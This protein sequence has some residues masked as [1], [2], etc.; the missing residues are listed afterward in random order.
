MPAP[1]GSDRE[2]TERGDAAIGC[3]EKYPELHKQP[4][5]ERHGVSGPHP[6]CRAML[7]FTLAI[8]FLTDALG[9]RL[10]L[11]AELMCLRHQVAVLRRQRGGRVELTNGDRWFMVLFFRL[12]PEIAKRSSLVTPGTLLRWHRGGFRAY[13]R[14]KSRAK[15]GRPR[16]DPATIALIKRMARENFLWGAPRIHGELLK[17]GFTIAESTVAKYMPRRR[18]DGPTWRT[19]IVNEFDGIDAMDMFDV[20]TATFEQVYAL[21]I[22]ALKKRRLV[23]LTATDHP[24]AQWL[25]QQ[26]REAFPW[27]TAPKILLRDNDKRYGDVFKRT[28]RNHGIRDHPISPK[29]PWQNGYVERV[30]GTIRRECLDHVIILDENHLRRV[31]SKFAA[32]YNESRTHLSLG[33]DAPEGRPAEHDGEITSITVLGGL[34][35]PVQKM[36]ERERFEY[37]VGTRVPGI[38]LPV[39]ASIRINSSSSLVGQFRLALI[40][41]CPCIRATKKFST[42]PTTVQKVQQI[43][44]KP[45]DKRKARCI[46]NGVGSAR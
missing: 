11:A 9:P 21:A 10:A 36:R 31:L 40:L 32:Y 12:W 22:I 5:G 2:A 13:W 35:H 27:D 44:N 41:S 26:I 15:P 30:I 20:P 25:A 17:L 28:V 19:F 6:H 1:S 7:A 14:W 43:P 45:R 18:R 16:I 33:K 29:S 24:T 23:L 42:Q 34:H 8:R 39:P 3:G 4:S 46:S 38:F 37:S